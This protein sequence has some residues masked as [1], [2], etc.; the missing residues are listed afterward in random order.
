MSGMHPNVL[1]LYVTNPLFT[2]GGGDPAVVENTTGSYSEEVNPGDTLI[3]PDETIQILD[4][5]DNII[6]TDTNPVYDE[7]VINM[8][9]FR[10]AE[11]LDFIFTVD[12]TIPNVSPA[13]SFQLS[14]TSTPNCVVYWGDGTSDILNA[15]TITSG[16]TL[17]HQYPTPGIYDIEI[18]GRF[19]YRTTVPASHDCL[20]LIAIKQWGM[21]VFTTMNYAFGNSHNLASVPQNETLKMVGNDFRLAFYRCGTNTGL[22]NFGKISTYGYSTFQQ[23]FQDTNFDY[24]VGDWNMTQATVLT[25]MFLGTSM[26]VANCDAILT[27]WTRWANGQANIQL[28]PNLSLHLGNTDYTR[29]GDAEVAHDYLVNT[30]GWTITFG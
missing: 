9:S 17:T 11:K 1:A 18:D 7:K 27:G 3:L 19:N 15:L 16:N 5:N 13:D 10:P 12:T 29:G 20:K 26:S 23:T 24:N 22:S 8:T 28:R 6:D 14:W 21:G 4:A 2:P 30:L 25:N